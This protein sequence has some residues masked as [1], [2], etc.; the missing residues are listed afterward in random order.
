[1]LADACTL[2]VKPYKINIPKGDI[3]DLHT[4]LKVG[5]ITR[6]LWENSGDSSQ[7]NKADYGIKREWLIRARDAWL[8]YDWCVPCPRSADAGLM[9]RRATEAK[10]NELPQYTTNLSL[11]REGKEEK[12]DIHFLAYHST[13]TDAVP[14]LFTHGWPGLFLEF[15]P[16]MQ[17]LEAEHG[18]EL[19]FHAIIPSLP[20]YAFSSAPS[21]E[22]QFTTEDVGQLWDQLMRG[23]GY[24]RYVAQGGDYG[25]FV[26]HELASAQEG[27]IAAHLN[28]A[29]LNVPPEG[30][31]E[32]EGMKKM[33]NPAPAQVLQ[34]ML[35]FGYALEH[36]TKPATVGAAVGAS[37]I[38]LL[39]W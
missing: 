33:G 19:P 30:T 12:Y 39:A 9:R 6:Q 5:R 38:G 10:L 14:V 22:R 36:G 16:M 15:V 35:G 37:P 1:M 27:C 29:L 28:F 34:G 13:R 17:R 11:T 21:T 20:G 31:P 4:A 7:T 3:D 8:A 25:A 26:T 2:N 24:P 32:Y 23:L 18:T